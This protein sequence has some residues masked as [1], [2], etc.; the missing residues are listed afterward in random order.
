M[1]ASFFL[2]TAALLTC[3]W[4]HGQAN[5]QKNLEKLIA[6]E[7]GFA[8]M[9]ESASFKK[10]FLQ[11]LDSTGIVFNGA[12]PV[13]GISFY[14]KPPDNNELLFKWYPAYA[15]L[16]GNGDMGFTTGPYIIISNKNKDTIAGGK[17]FSIWHKNKEGVFKVLLDGGVNDSTQHSFAFGKIKPATAAGQSAAGISASKSKPF[18]E[19]EKEFTELAG[20]NLLKAYEK[21]MAKQS[22]LLRADMATG[23][24]KIAN[25]ET[26]KKT[27]ITSCN[28][29]KKDTRTAADNTLCF[30]YGTAKIVNHQNGK[31]QKGY[32]VQIW[33]YQQ[34]G[35][36][37]IADVLQL[38]N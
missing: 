8:A 29:D 15:E 31:D 38:I 34:E 1:N 35:W 19:C 3:S 27:S 5:Q 37:I 7:N 13:N 25:L 21:Y 9:A 16:P 17:F 14:K 36:K 32:F 24:N 22:Y 10:A 18:T 2:F 20:N 4:S 11:N 23:L 33:Q 12:E 26:L 6:A 28:F 30:N